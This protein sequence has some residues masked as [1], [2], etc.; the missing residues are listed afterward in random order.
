[1]FQGGAYARIQSLYVEFLFDLTQ[2]SCLWNF[3]F[4]WSVL[5]CIGR[6]ETEEKCMVQE[7]LV[8]QVWV[9]DTEVNFLVSLWIDF[10]CWL[11]FFTII[12]MFASIVLIFDEICQI[13]SKL[14]ETPKQA[15]VPLYNRQYGI[16]SWRWVSDATFLG[17]LVLTLIW[18]MMN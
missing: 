5:Q 8:S 3:S 13:I 4:L 6:Y 1:M 16:I 14:Q 2:L 10:A 12:F 15:Y 17:W 7:F 18:Y 9:V 11:V